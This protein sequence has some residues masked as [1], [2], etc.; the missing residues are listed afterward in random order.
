MKKLVFA[1]L[2]L[3][4]CKGD[5][6]PAPSPSPASGSAP[7]AVAIDAAAPAPTPPP[8]NDVCQIGRAAIDAAKCAK[9]EVASQLA[10]VKKSLDGVVDMVK[11]LGDGGDPTKFHVMCAQMLLALERDATKLGCTVAL[12][13]ANRDEIM[14]LLEA[15]YAQRTEVVK[16]G[17]AAADAVIDKLAA[18][19]DATCACKDGAC[20]AGLEKQLLAVGEMPKTA[21]D[22][23]RTLG[24]KLLEDAARC[25][26]R[27]RTILDP[28]K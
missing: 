27:V 3:V 4:A 28:P 2:L 25:A 15:W 9:P 22:A 7:V 17:D 16:T 19:R 6:P 20:L 18:V 5:K 10:K 21:P 14:K 24:S 13:P 11:Q 12:D 26:N 1:A 8:A 23:A